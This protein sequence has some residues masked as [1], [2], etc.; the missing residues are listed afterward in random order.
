[1]KKV[2]TR[3]IVFDKIATSRSEAKVNLSE[4][5]KHKWKGHSYL[6]GKVSY[7]GVLTKG[8][9]LT[10]CE[11]KFYSREFGRN[12]LYG[13]VRRICWSRKGWPCVQIKEVFVCAQLPLSQWYKWFY[14]FT[15]QIRYKWGKYDSCV[16]FTHLMKTTWLSWYYMWMTCWLHVWICQ[17]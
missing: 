17:M 1:M 14:S 12:Y 9:G 10:W 6:Q 5:R 7:I 3:D 2:L 16:Y 15:V 11:D 4:E 13:S 8:A